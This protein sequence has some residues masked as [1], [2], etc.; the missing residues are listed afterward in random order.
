MLDQHLRMLM[1]IAEARRMHGTS[2]RDGS[3]HEVYRKDGEQKIRINVGKRPDGSPWL[4]PWIKIEDHHGA[5]REQHKF[6]KGQNV[7]LTAAGAD[8]SQAKVTPAGENKAHP[9]PD[10]ADDVNQTSQYGKHRSRIGPDFHEHWLAGDS[11]NMA[12]VPG[13]TSSQSKQV[14]PDKESVVLNRVGAK[15]QQQQDKGQPWEGPD[16]NGGSAKK[17]R[18]TWAGT[19]GN[20]PTVNG[21]VIV[22][23]FD[24]HT[25][26]EHGAG[27][28]LNKIQSADGAAM[29]SPDAGDGSAQKI[30]TDLMQSGIVTRKIHDTVAGKVTSTV[31]SNGDVTHLIE[32]LMGNKSKITQQMN[33]T[34]H[35]HQTAGGDFS[36]ILQQ[37]G[38][39]FHQVTSGGQTSTLQISGG[40]VDINSQSVNING[41]SFTTSSTPPAT[42]VANSSGDAPLFV[43][44]ELWSIE[45]GFVIEAN[46]NPYMAQKWMLEGQHLTAASVVPQV[47]IS[48]PLQFIASNLSAAIA[49]VFR[50]T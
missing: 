35:Q 41:N 23:Q 16:P 3:V 8:F 42:P 21:D 48:R 14:D 18:L 33:Q 49:G 10:H 46:V 28:I 29:T 2:E 4:T 27:N 30:T 43:I 50:G 38:K 39:I 11:Q 45:A 36:F 26:T 17:Q 12:A 15:P 5:L 1:Q 9:E 32:D 44:P 31:H 20:T 13:G 24:K 40:A 22:T 25:K 7:K 6:H 34:I 37:S 19:K 47:L